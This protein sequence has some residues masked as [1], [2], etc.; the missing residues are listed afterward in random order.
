MLV[1]LKEGSR[2]RLNN[3]D[4]LN[5]LHRVTSIDFVTILLKNVKS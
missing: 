3:N 2:S 1:S 4:I 5:Y